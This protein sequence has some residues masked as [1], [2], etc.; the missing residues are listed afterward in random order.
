MSRAD[1]R[2]LIIVQMLAERGEMTAAEMRAALDLSESQFDEAVGI[3]RRAGVAIPRAGK[4]R[5]SSML[6][7]AALGRWKCGRSNN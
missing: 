7:G 5:P 6:Q 4:W 2:A 1:Q 3:A